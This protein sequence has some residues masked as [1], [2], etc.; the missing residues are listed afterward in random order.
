MTDLKKLNNEIRRLL[1]QLNGRQKATLGAFGAMIL[2]P[3]LWISVRP[4]DGTWL[5][6][7]QGRE[8]D[9]DLAH[10]VEEILNQSGLTDVH[11]DNH[12]IYVPSDQL[13]LADAAL[14]DSGISRPRDQTEPES[15]SSIFGAFDPPEAIE[16]E[17][18]ER[19]QRNIE[20]GLATISGIESATVI[21][22]RSK[23]RRWG[24]KPEVAAAVY[25]SPTTGGRLTSELRTSICTSVANAIPDLMPERI[26]VIDRRSGRSWKSDSDGSSMADRQELA[27]E[28]ETAIESELTWI[29]EVQAIVRLSETPASSQIH[30][31]MKQASTTNRSIPNRPG[32]LTAAANTML[33]P[34]VF[35]EVLVPDHSFTQVVS[36]GGRIPATASERIVRTVKNILPTGLQAEIVVNRKQ[37]VS[38]AEFRSANPEPVGFSAVL[39][40]FSA[41]VLLLA[42][43][44]SVAVFAFRMR[45]APPATLPLPAAT[46]LASDS[47]QTVPIPTDL[48][49]ADSAESFTDHSSS[50][51]DQSPLTSIESAE[52]PEPAETAEQ[53]P[54]EIF[55]PRFAYLRQAEPRDI[56]RL[57]A[58]E[59]PQTVALVLRHLPT[60]QATDVVSLL[61]ANIQSQV[62]RRI[63]EADLSDSE[64]VEE[65]EQTLKT[66]F[67]TK[68]AATESAGTMHRPSLLTPL[69]QFEEIV[70]LSQPNLKRVVE[71]V[72]ESLWV[73]A[74]HGASETLRFRVIAVLPPQQARS[75][76]SQLSHDSPRPTDVESTRN[77]IVKTVNALGLPDNSQPLRHEFVA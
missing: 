32:V 36:D 43:L 26:V 9:P 69:A 6:V 12:R 8:L 14:T 75:V 45:S 44:L 17:S 66:R 47:S 13:R 37:P 70:Q 55:Q 64:V 11:T 52:A 21:S 53:P 72:E 56:H 5:A 73:Q 18:R 23:P 29:P 63:A 30:T 50:G 16:R 35:V 27:E 59:H 25:I 10:Q 33:Q 20:Q 31:V 65:L 22:S 34:S 28:Y 15:R 60:K 49:V 71:E 76:R 41:G 38:P 4:S 24:Q 58:G 39:P 3:L 67:T 40:G 54:I 46:A 19:L 74:L 57:L 61:P 62:I 1:R 51:E 48:I 77:R 7:L 2:L 42:V 68:L